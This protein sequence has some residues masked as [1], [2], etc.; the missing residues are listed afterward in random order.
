MNGLEVAQI[1]GTLA[2]GLSTFH[3]SRNKSLPFYKCIFSAFA[4]SALFYIGAAI[5]IYYMNK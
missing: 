1:F 4:A 5:A 2:V 3:I